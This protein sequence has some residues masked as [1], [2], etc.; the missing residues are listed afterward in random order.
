MQVNIYGTDSRYTEM[1]SS[2]CLVSWNKEI[3]TAQ[4]CI[5]S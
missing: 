3:D 2:F 5:C 4:I 1:F